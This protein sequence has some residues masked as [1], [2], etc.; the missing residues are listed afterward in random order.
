MRRQTVIV[1]LA[2][3]SVPSI[4]TTG[5][6]TRQVFFMDKLLGVALDAQGYIRADTA[7][8]T[9]V[10]GVFAAGDVT[11]LFSHQITTAVHEGATAATAANQCLYP[12]ALQ[13]S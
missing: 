8:K 13:G 9:N 11:R 6:S 1:Q 4:A 7:Q 2:Y 3:P 5:L 10:P 12:P